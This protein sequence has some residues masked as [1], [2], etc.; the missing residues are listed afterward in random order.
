MED[1]RKH[2]IIG[3]LLAKAASSTHEGEKQDFLRKAEVFMADLGYDVEALAAE[4]K[5]AEPVIEDEKSA[6]VTVSWYGKKFSVLK[7]ELD[8]G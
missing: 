5:N 4:G 3:N 1:T 7:H 6:W 2:T 8:K